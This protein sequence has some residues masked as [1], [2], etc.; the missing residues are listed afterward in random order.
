V[1]NGLSSA[2]API[3]ALATEKFQCNVCQMNCTNARYV[4]PECLHSYCGDCIEE[5]LRMFGNE[6]PAC[7][8]NGT[9]SKRDGVREDKKIDNVSTH[10]DVI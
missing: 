8:V 2:I 10:N 7:L 6:C 5:C 1:L 4:V 9:T 3:N